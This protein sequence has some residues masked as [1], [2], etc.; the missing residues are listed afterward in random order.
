MNINLKLF[1]EEYNDWHSQ[2]CGNSKLKQNRNRDLQIMS[3]APVK[4]MR[5]A[6]ATSSLAKPKAAPEAD[7]GSNSNII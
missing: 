7:I 6:T 5:G 3:Q 2:N 1:I 4:N